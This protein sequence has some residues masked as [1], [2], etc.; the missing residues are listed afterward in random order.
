MAEGGELG[1]G[2]DGEGGARGEGVSTEAGD[3]VVAE[4]GVIGSSKVCF[5]ENVR[6]VIGGVAGDDGV[7]EEECSPSCSWEVVID[8]A[9][10]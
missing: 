4:G 1:I 6:A 8:S 5:F 7:V 10:F 9:S 3:E 2:I